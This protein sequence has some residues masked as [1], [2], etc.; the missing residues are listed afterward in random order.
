M[1]PYLQ[2]EIGDP[3]DVRGRAVIHMEP[4]TN[5]LLD[6]N[7]TA[8]QEAIYTEIL[9]GRLVALNLFEPFYVKIGEAG[10]SLSHER[11]PEFCKKECRDLV[12]A[13]GPEDEEL[14]EPEVWLEQAIARYTTIY[15][16]KIYC[17]VVGNLVQDVFHVCK[18]AAAQTY[19]EYLF[20]LAAWICQATCA[21][22]NRDSVELCYAK[23]RL[24]ELRTHI[25]VLD[26]KKIIHAVTKGDAGAWYEIANY[27]D[28]FFLTLKKHYPLP[29]ANGNILALNSETMASLEESQT[30]LL[31]EYFHALLREE[32]EKAMEL[33]PLLEVS[34]ISESLEGCSNA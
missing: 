10:L 34:H 31:E 22:R 7:G 4:K 19:Y 1:H 13:C 3:D 29:L 12:Y 14:S 5:K 16:E 15:R 23:K 9:G 20:K 8:L 33:K 25:A 17:R 11:I 6:I 21:R 27:V 26:V 24:N 28:M 2:L 30:A 18:R 32:Y